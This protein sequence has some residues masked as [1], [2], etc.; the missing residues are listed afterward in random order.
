MYRD[1]Q[2]SGG[3]LLELILSLSY[4]VQ[5]RKHCNYTKVRT[6]HHDLVSKDHGRRVNSSVLANTCI[7]NLRKMLLFLN[8]ILVHNTFT[9]QTFQQFIC[10]IRK[11]LISKAFDE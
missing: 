5:N 3:Q 2:L 7:L 4:N 10:L 11:A 1:S 8:Q 9:A 6:G